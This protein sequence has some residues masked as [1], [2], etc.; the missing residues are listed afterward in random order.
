MESPILVVLYFVFKQGRY[1]NNTG[2]LAVFAPFFIHYV[3]RGKRLFF[4]NNKRISESFYQSYVAVIFPHR[5]RNEGKQMMVATI[6]LSFVFYVVNGYFIGYY[7]GHLEEY[8]K[9]GDKF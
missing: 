2:N 6:I 4:R 8:D 9:G 5:M 3:H 7:F 1:A